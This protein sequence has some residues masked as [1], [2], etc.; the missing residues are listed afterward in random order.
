M[1]A[2]K[3]NVANETSLAS[4]EALRSLFRAQPGLWR[5]GFHSVF[6][7]ATGDVCM[8]ENCGVSGGG[9]KARPRTASE[10]FTGITARNFAPGNG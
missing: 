2:Q 3:G 1:I 4:T 9:S 5:G 7:H 8:A 6:L 10:S